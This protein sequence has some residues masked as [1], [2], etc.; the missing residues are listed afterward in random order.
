MLVVRECHA[1]HGKGGCRVCMV[2][3][4]RH[5]VRAGALY[6]SRRRTLNTQR[7]YEDLE[8]CMMMMMIPERRPNCLQCLS[9]T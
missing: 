2:S 1:E 5:P 3:R 9:G 8:R 4:A 6:C 7:R